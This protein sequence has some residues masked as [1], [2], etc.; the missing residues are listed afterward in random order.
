MDVFEAL[1]ERINRLIE[2]YRGLGARVE[3]LE[4][5]NRELRASGDGSTGLQDRIAALESEREELRGRLERVI[6][7]LEALDV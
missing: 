1:E 5:E 4:A 3:E 2:A 6:A 7:R